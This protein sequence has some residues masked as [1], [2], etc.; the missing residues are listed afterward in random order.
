MKFFS[1]TAIVALAS[2]LLQA[3]AACT[4]STC[5]CT[6][7]AAG[8]MCGNESPDFR[9]INGHVYQCS[10]NGHT[11]DFGVRKECNSCGKPTC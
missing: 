6:G 9:C 11:C 4:S 7:H 1:V 2:A 8:L 10:S 5:P 3:Q